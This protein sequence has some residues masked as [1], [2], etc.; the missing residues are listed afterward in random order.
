MPASSSVS[1]SER[2]R[3]ETMK[4]G[5]S[6]SALDPLGFLLLGPLPLQ[7]WLGLID[8]DD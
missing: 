1:S 6:G 7:G 4:G 3:L 2:S 8:V 5:P